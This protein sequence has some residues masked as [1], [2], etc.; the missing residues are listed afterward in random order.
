MKGY[1]YKE[2]KQNRLFLLLTAV[3]AM[4]VAFLPIILVMINEKTMAKEAFLMFAQ[5]GMF[6]RILCMLAGFMGAMKMQELAL[7]GD[8]VKTWRYF[9]ASGP[10]GIG[11]YI[12]TKYGIIGAMCVMYFALCAG[13]DFMFTFIANYIGRIGIPAMA[14][15][16]VV[17][18]FLQ[19]LL[20]AVE[21]PFTFR[22]GVKKGNTIKTILMIGIFVIFMLVSM[23][24]PAGIAELFSNLA[25][26]EIPD[27][28]KWVLP[29]VSIIIYVLSCM[30]SC[31]LYLKGVES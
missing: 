31:K 15:V 1:L 22:F 4:C 21:I 9:V 6:L 13:F 12:R 17:L 29:V 2:W 7:N 14:E 20:N 27:Y 11:S 16:F 25:E 19:L 8:D 30:L 5:Y 26:G 28:T 24:N 10:K 18:L 23:I 3:I